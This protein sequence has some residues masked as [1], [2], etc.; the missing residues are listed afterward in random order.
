[1]SD[2]EVL[3]VITD[4]INRKPNWVKTTRKYEE[5]NKKQLKKIRHLK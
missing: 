3:T 1:M 4:K 5:E 2:S